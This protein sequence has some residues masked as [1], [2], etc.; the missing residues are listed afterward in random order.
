[1]GICFLRDRSNTKKMIAEQLETSLI[2]IEL[3]KR[4][5]QLY[6]WLLTPTMFQKHFSIFQAA[7]HFFSHLSSISH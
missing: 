4:I 2:S 1:M 6:G 5:F 7:A 3:P